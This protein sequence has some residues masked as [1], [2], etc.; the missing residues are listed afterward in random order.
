MG[1]MEL[2]FGKVFCF[3]NEIPKKL[4]EKDVAGYS[5]VMFS[6]DTLGLPRGINILTSIHKDFDKEV[7]RLTQELPHCLPCRDKNGKRM[8]CFYTVYVHFL[9]QHLQ[10]QGK[11]R[12][13]LEKKN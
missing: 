7:I 2:R 8:E 4:L 9:P 3:S 13:V 1:N 12:I 6:L 11:K 5:V 10:R